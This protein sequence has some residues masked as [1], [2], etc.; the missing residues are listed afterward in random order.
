MAYNYWR[1][2]WRKREKNTM[3]QNGAKQSECEQQVPD[4]RKSG[5]FLI[6]SADNHSGL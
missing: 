1:S 4:T 5:S 6:E 3:R 2:F